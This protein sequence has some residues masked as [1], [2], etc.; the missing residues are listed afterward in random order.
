MNIGPVLTEPMPMLKATKNK[1]EKNIMVSETNNK[2][3]LLALKTSELPTVLLE[4]I[5]PISINFISSNSNQ[6]GPLTP[7]GDRIE[8]TENVKP[9]MD[10]Y[11]KSFLAGMDMWQSWMDMYN[12]FIIIWIRLSL[13]WSDQFWKLFGHFFNGVP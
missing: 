13:N 3:N 5:K 1:E 11:F 12:E 2:S 6:I 7:Q 8:T 10:Y 4:E 9:M